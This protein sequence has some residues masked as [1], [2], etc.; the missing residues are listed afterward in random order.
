MQSEQGLQLFYSEVKKPM[1][2]SLKE[3]GKQVTGV[4]ASMTLRHFMNPKSYD[5]L[6]VLLDRYPYHVVE[7]SCY[8]VCWGTLIG[9][10]TAFWEVRLGY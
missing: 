1:R 5:W 2:D 8:G 9:Y 3:G 10:N 7:F 4:V 6:Q